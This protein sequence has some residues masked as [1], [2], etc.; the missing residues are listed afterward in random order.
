MLSIILVKI[1]PKLKWQIWG[2]LNCH[3]YFDAV[4]WAMASW[5]HGGPIATDDRSVKSSSRHSPSTD[6]SKRAIVTTT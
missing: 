5:P 1:P 2:G 3:L 6:A 4:F